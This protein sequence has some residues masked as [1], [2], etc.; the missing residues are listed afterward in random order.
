MCGLIDAYVARKIADMVY[1]MHNGKIV[2]HG[3]A[4]KI[5]SNPKDDYTKKLV[6]NGCLVF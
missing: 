5:F 3:V 6:K 4:S 1:V 2:E